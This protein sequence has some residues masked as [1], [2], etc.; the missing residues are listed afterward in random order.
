MP[1]KNNPLKLNNLQRKTLA[2]LQELAHD[3]DEQTVDPE[4][5]ALLITELPQPHGDHFH[6]GA[7]VVATRNATGLGNESVWKALERKGLIRAV[8]FPY[9]VAITDAGLAYETGMRDAILLQSDH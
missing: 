6:V 5:G 1:P 4:S 9:A 2:L 8:A 3:Q 7:G